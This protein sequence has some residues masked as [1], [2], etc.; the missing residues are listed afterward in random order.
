MLIHP[1]SVDKVIGAGMDSLFECLWGRLHIVSIIILI[2]EFS[3][4]GSIHLCGVTSAMVC[5]MQPCLSIYLE[6]PLKSES[7]LNGSK[8]FAIVMRAPICYLV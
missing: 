5:S 4:F 1:L 2:L 8:E 6:S 3:W 7:I